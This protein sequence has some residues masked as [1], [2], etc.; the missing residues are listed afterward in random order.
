[1]KTT[2][3][4]LTLGKETLRRL[5][6]GDLGRVHGGEG[7]TVAPLPKPQE[8]E[9]TVS[10]YCSQWSCLAASCGCPVIIVS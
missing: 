3:R 7:K 8:P 10:C 5:D 6:S 2:S 1:M 9:K 4:K